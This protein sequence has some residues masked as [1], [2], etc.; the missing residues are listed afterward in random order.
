MLVLLGLMVLVM[1]FVIIDVM[2]WWLVVIFVLLL[3]GFFV[4]VCWFVVVMV[5][6]FDCRYVF[7]DKGW[8]EDMVELEVGMEFF[9]V[10]DEFIFWMIDFDCL[11]IVLEGLLWDD[12][13]VIVLIY[14]LML[15][16]V[17]MVCII[18]LFVFG[19]VFG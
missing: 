11:V 13:V 4:F 12:V 2:L 10:E 16:G 19:L 7:I 17:W 1:V 5:K 3:V 9:C 8:D 14:V 6:C 15:L 18:D